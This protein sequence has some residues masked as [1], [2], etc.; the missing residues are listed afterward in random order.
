MIDWDWRRRRRNKE[1]TATKTH[2]E[3][4]KDERGGTEGGPNTNERI[5][6]TR[7]AGAGVR[8]RRR[9]EAQGMYFRRTGPAA[10]NTL[11]AATTTLRLATSDEKKETS[12]EREMREK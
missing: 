1:A 10:T 12:D 3:S 7:D 6:S 9:R 2:N 8:A 11:P 4:H 5:F